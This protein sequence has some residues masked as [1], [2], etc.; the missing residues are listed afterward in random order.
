MIDIMK[1]YLVDNLTPICIS[2]FSEYSQSQRNIA[3]PPFFLIWNLASF[4]IFYLK[5]ESSICYFSADNPAEIKA[6]VH[7]G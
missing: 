6:V 4:V 2:P 7:F 5:Q 3:S 1:K